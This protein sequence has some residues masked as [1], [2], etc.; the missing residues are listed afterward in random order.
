MG[1]TEAMAEHQPRPLLSDKTEAAIL[2]LGS[3][4]GD[5]Q[6]IRRTVIIVNSD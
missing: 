1:K 2:Y 5:R 4:G 3:G 6:D